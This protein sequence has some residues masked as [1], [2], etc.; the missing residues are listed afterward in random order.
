VHYDFDAQR[1]L[2]VPAQVRAQLR[3]QDPE[4]VE[5]PS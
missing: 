5:Q 1:S 2:P 3:A 4:L